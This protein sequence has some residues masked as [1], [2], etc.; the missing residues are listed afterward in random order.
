MRG[1]SLGY[2]RVC[3]R[4]HTGGAVSRSTA[5]GMGNGHTRRSV[6][7]CRAIRRLSR[8]EGRVCDYVERMANA[9]TNDF[10]GSRE[11]RWHDLEQRLA[12]EADR[13]A[14]R[15]DGLYRQAGLTV[16]AVLDPLWRTNASA[17]RPEAHQGSPKVATGRPWAS[18]GT[19]ERRRW[20]M[21][22]WATPAPPGEHVRPPRWPRRRIWN[23]EDALGVAFR[24]LMRQKSYKRISLQGFRHIPQDPAV[25][26]LP[27]PLWD[28][29]WCW[30]TGHAVACMRFTKAQGSR[31]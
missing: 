21:V 12:S 24:G 18:C 23:T 5:K 11:M 30:F 29:P 28:C 19:A 25:P 2:P 20:G 17:M 6:V 31:M 8:L 4:W 15:M 26:P 1:V 10:A 9:D 3:E 14:D 27:R 16:D 22:A 7:P 13:V